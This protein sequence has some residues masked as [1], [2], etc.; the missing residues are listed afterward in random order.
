V[1]NETT[2]RRGNTIC[3]VFDKED[4]GRKRQEEKTSYPADHAHYQTLCHSIKREKVY[5]EKDPKPPH[6]EVKISSTYHTGRRSTSNL[7]NLQSALVESQEDN[8]IQSTSAAVP[9][10]PDQIQ[11]DAASQARPRLK[12]IRGEVTYHHIRLAQGLPEKTGMD[13]SNWVAVS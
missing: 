12:Q 5:D 2:L 8:Y 3:L 1:T 9:K 7:G 4:I 13:E 6:R 10:N 11:K